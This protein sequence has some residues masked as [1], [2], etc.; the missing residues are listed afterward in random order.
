M[1]ISFVTRHLVDVMV[2]MLALN[3]ID[4][5]FKPQ[6]G[7]IKDYQIGICWFSAKYAT[8]RNKSKN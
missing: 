6:L 3:E 2:R 8:L 5:G 4:H 7:Q 1:A